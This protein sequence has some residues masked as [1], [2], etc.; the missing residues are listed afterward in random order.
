MIIRAEGNEIKAEMSEDKV[1]PSL[2]IN[3][4]PIEPVTAELAEIEIV[5]ATE[6]ERLALVW[7]G[8]FLCLARTK[9]SLFDLKS[10]EMK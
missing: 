9:K 2:L 10:Q 3:G 7:G 8:Y 4:V 5:E 6:I 1:H